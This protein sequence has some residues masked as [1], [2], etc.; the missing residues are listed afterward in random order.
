MRFLSWRPGQATSGR[1]CADCPEPSGTRRPARLEHHISTGLRRLS[2]LCGT[3]LRRMGAALALGLF[4]ATGFAAGA[5][6][7]SVLVSN[8]G[9]S[10]SNQKELLN[11]IDIAQTFTTGAD[12]NGYTLSSVVIEFAKLGDRD[13]IASKLTASINANNSGVPGTSLG[14]LTASNSSRNVLTFSAGPSGISLEANTTYFFTIDVTEALNKNN[15]LRIA[16]NSAV[17]AGGVAGWSIGNKRTR[18]RTVSGAWSSSSSSASSLPFKITINGEVNTPGVTV[19]PA[20]LEVT[21]GATA[22]YDVVLDTAPTGNVVITPTSSATAKATVSP[23]TL[24]FTS[25]NWNQAQQVTVNGVAA[26]SANISHQVTTSADTTNY[27]TSMSIDP[28]AVTVTGPPVISI[29]G[30]SALVEGANAT[31]TVTS[32]PAPA[33]DLTVKLSVADFADSDFLAAENE[34]E[35]SVTIPAGRSSVVY[36]FPT[37]ADSK[38]EVAGD[39]S[40]TLLDG[41]GYTLNSDASKASIKI[42]SRDKATLTFSSATATATEGAGAVTITASLDHTPDTELFLGDPRKLFPGRKKPTDINTSFGFT[43]TKLDPDFP[44]TF[45]YDDDN[46]DRPDREIILDLARS[47]LLSDLVNISDFS[48]RALVELGTQASMTLTLIDNDPTAVTLTV[49]DTSADEGDA[50]DTAEIKLTLGRGLVTGEEMTV[51]L[52][53]SGGTLGTAFTL[54]LSGSPNGVTLDAN[55]GEVTFTGGDP[56][57]ATA[58][59]VLLTASDDDG[60]V[61]ESVTVT[62]P[63]S[64]TGSAPKLTATGL[65][66]GATGSGSGVITITDDD[67]EAALVIAQA[68][69]AALVFAQA[70]DPLEVPEGGSA[71]YTVALATEPTGTVTVT[72]TQPTNT[73]VTV[74]TDTGTNGNQATLSFTTANWNQPQTVTVAA[75]Q[76]VDT[77]DDSAAIS[78]SASGGG[79]GSV[80][81]TVSV[82]VSDDDGAGVIITETDGGTAVGNSY[83]KVRE[84]TYEVVLNSQPTHDVTI[85]VTSGDTQGATVKKSGGSEVESLMLTFTPDTWNTAQT[86]TVVGHGN[87]AGGPVSISHV[88]T[89]DDTAYGG[90]EVDPVSVAVANVIPTPGALSLEEGT[91]GTFKLK[92]D[93]QPSADVTVALSGRFFTGSFYINEVTFTPAALTF[94][95]DNWNTAQ[96]V[97][98]T[99]V[100]ND[101]V[102]SGGLLGAILGQIEYTA[103]SSDGTYEGSSRN[104]DVVVSDDDMAGVTVTETVLNVEEGGS[105]TYTVVLTSEPTRDVTIA[106]TSDDTD[107]ATVD[108]N[109]L[110][111]TPGNWNQPQSV[112]VTGVDDTVD[113]STGRTASI[114]HVATS[115][116]TNYGGIE[117]ASVGVTVTDDDTVGVV[118]TATGGST[119]VSEDG[120]LTDSYQVVLGTPPTQD[121]TIAVTSDDTDV[122]TTNTNTLTFTSSNWNQP[123]TVTVTGVDDDIDQSTDRT[124]SI[125]H[126]AT[127]DDTN[128]GGIEVASVSVTV[129]DDDT[130]DVTVTETE[131][132]TT[133]SEDGTLTDSYQVVLTSEPSANVTIAVTSGDTNIATVDT[134]TL[135]FTPGNWNQPQTVTVTG[136]DDEVSQSTGRRVSISHV[137]T[138]GDT[139]YNGIEVASVSVTVTDGDTPGVIIIETDGGTVV[140][141]AG[142]RLREDTYQV[143]L[144]SQPTHDVMIA[145]TSGNINGALVQ[146]SGV[147]A[148]GSVTLTFTPDTW[149]TAQTVTVIGSAGAGEEDQASISHVATS[150]DTAYNGIEVD[151]VSVAVANMIRNP[152]SLRLEEGTSGTFTLVLTIQPSADVT[153]ALSERLSTNAVTFSPAALTFTADTW[154]QAQDVTVTAVDNDV[155]A[156]GRI[157]EIISYAATSSDG[158]YD[159][160]SYAIN[161]TVTDDDEAGVTV[162]ETILN[163]EEGGSGTYTLVLDS[164]PSADVTIAVAPSSRFVATAS[165]ATLTFTADNWNE[166]QQVTVRAMDNSV[167]VPGLS[168]FNTQINHTVTS[169]DD[170]YDEIDVASVRV[171]ISDNDEAGVTVNPT[172]LDVE[173]GGSGTYTLVLDSQPG[174]DVTIAVAPSSRSVATASPATLTFTASNWNEAQQVT[175]RA[176]DNS[177]VVPGLSVFN[178]QINHTVTSS[179]DMYDEIDVASVRVAISDN[180]EV[181]VTVTETEG[182]TTVSEDGTVTDS[183]QVVLATQPS[184]NVTIAV[185]S[186]DTDAATVDSDTLTFTPGNWNQPQSVTVTGVDDDIDQSTDRTVSISHVATSDDTAYGGIEVASVSVTVE[187][188]DEAAL[189]FAQAADPLEVSEGGSAAYTVALA[190]QPTA[191]VTVTLTQPANT[192]V[193]VDTDTGMDT[194]QTTLSFTTVNW[195]APQTVTAAAA[196]DDDAADD[197]AAISHSAS[198]GGYGSV[199]GTVSVSVTDDDEAGVA[200]TEMEDGTTVSE[201][202]TVT[203]SYQVVLATQPSANVT[204]AVTSDDTDAAT[205]DSDTLTFTP[206]NWNQPQSVTVTGVDDDIDQSTDRTV[207]ISHVA[208]SEDTAYGGIEVA[209]VSVTVSDDDEAAVGFVEAAS[210]VPERAGTHE[211]TLRFDVVSAAPLELRYSLSGTATAGRDFT[212]GDGVLRVPAQAREVTLPVTILDDG[213]QEADET[214]VVTLIEDR[215]GQYRLGSTTTHTL[216]ITD[217][218][219]DLAERVV[220]PALARFGRTVGEQVLDAVT[221]RLGAARTP[222]FEGRFAGEALPDVICDDGKSAPDHVL[223]DDDRRRKCVGQGRYEPGSGRPADPSVAAWSNGL[224]GG[225]GGTPEVQAKETSDI[226]PGTSFALTSET[227]NGAALAFWGRGAQSGFS[228]RAGDLGLEGEVTSF[229]LG[230]DQ[231]RDDWLFGLMLSRSRG[232]IDYTLGAASG[233]METDLTALVPYMG[234]D[235][236]D[237]LSVWG[238]AGLGSGDMR[239]RPEDGSEFRT[240]IDWGMA[241]AGADG[242]L[243]SVAALGG[244]ELRWLADALWTRTTSDAV[245][246]LEATSGSTTRLRLGLESR[247]EH[248]FAS[249]ATLS[250]RLETGLR[251]DGGDAET[252]FGLE[253]GGGVE[254]TD[255]SRGLSLGLRGRTLAL[256]Q[257]GNFEDWGLALDLAYDPTPETKRG[258]AA[259]LSHTFGGASSGGVDALLGPR[260]FPEA[261]P[262]GGGDRSWSVEAAY[263]VS[264]GRGRVGSPYTTITAAG[265]G[266]ATGARLGYRIEP[267]ADHA[268]D[269]NL[270]FWTEPP[271]AANDRASGGATLQWKW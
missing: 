133:V 94:T 29:T 254:F 167:V 240:D 52:Q 56:V 122:A 106:V 11:S 238:A 251:Y 198:G 182:G 220:R 148:G 17:D 51:P 117:V 171:A 161:V 14:T 203:D 264:R 99:A 35:K 162:T 82:T 165:P 3:G 222:G 241:A 164:E 208:T 126:A 256:H 265:S 136:V 252:G 258:F 143:V 65:G 32:T 232:E 127:S 239:L 38:A 247:W 70:T 18:D 172:D 105:G 28:V 135:T 118:I 193:T 180:D 86:V 48:K 98:V 159:G 131:G 15:R 221:D 120:T 234:W 30:G 107:V 76:D 23:A 64:D 194:N 67:E 2:V 229:M 237:R 43:G 196:Q 61:S 236:S 22:T 34:G 188:D 125:S 47:A 169:S 92:L 205:V 173:E 150:D 260:L 152:G 226:L 248:S 78:H 263:G 10:D 228:G 115:G 113:Q 77:A 88:A 230:A 219:S 235:V 84:D 111:F 90:I 271:T 207:S 6:A 175:V 89:S 91:S 212:A 166:A 154:N 270:D 151:S 231:A 108:T 178:T 261:S 195:N 257:D 153:I 190:T 121:V 53:F 97:T 104:L 184:A 210:T 242:A 41:T 266:S 225:P 31:F 102:D 4:A 68:E 202:G 255:P 123:Q 103:T 149:N 73:D 246:G 267:D 176:M 119:T 55:T 58:A 69:E 42:L 250:P 16:A 141:N 96:E 39:V 223:E 59:T 243:G 201:D 72:L 27:P 186:D 25:S 83:T 140:G 37:V 124:V 44:F 75:A 215:G 87:H 204:I 218:D 142:S 155:V 191:T 36:K 217:D 185:T 74:D 45:S 116:D 8:D 7:Q 130:V 138:S 109:T 81:G 46:V 197:S 187:D 26:G 79:Y 63:A 147:N 132:G 40:V 211:V 177:V 163:V 128:Y 101:V 189:V 1:V 80:T 134:N 259:R 170:M 268:A 249:A 253:V 224:T 206:G 50:S 233:E 49:P 100:D 144:N 244:A 24:T 245:P 269:V 160:V 71:A 179:D 209:S 214:V 181:G 174:A 112:T 93:S 200:V 33:T 60:G 137:A 54:A 114:S 19:T 146:K 199:T 110:T 157:R 156:S 95:A 85:T 66:G 262:T 183:Y 227:E 12:G 139:A 145:V 13:V 62:I 216:T 9:Q 158:T 213:E 5:E 57:S 129:S 20:A 168:V 21:E 192:D